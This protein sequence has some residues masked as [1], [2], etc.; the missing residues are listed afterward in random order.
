MD[1]KLSSSVSN[2]QEL[3]PIVPKKYIAH[4]IMLISCFV[5]WG[6][7]NNMT[8]NLVPAF[9]RIFMLEA[10]DA[11]LTQVAF[12]GSYAVLALPAAILIKKY[13]YRTGVLVGLGLYIVGAM[14]YIPA[15]ISQNFN[16]FLTSVFILA[17]GLSI[18]ETTCNPYVISLGSPET[19]VRRLNL[20]QAFNPLGSL[21][22][23]IMAK[24][25]ILSNLNPATY[26]ERVAMS[27]DALSAI[28]SNELLWVCVPY[29]GLVAIALVIWLFFKKSKDSEKDTS[30]ELNITHSIKKLVRIPRYAFG[31]VAQFF[32]VGVQIAV[33]TWT[34]SYVMTNLGLDEAAASG[35]YLIAI[36][37]FIV[38]RWIC[39]ALMKYIDPAIM[40]AVFAVGG[41]VFSLGTIY[42]PTNQSVWCLVAISACMSLMFPTI[43][44]IALK[45]LGEEVKVGAAGLIMAILGGA[46]IT[47]IMGK[48]IDTGVLSSIV[49]SFTG[50]QAAVR[51][52]FL[53]PAIC[54]LVVL[55]Y[56]LCFRTK[57]E[58]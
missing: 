52:S 33:W 7:L 20:A 56:S 22:G 2:K 24:Y 57:K 26:E 36:I 47:P 44:G 5:L 34:I 27:P 8:D 54:F 45:D 29:V 14:G 11:S 43:Y 41:I 13:S 25:I 38:C 6:L 46:V 12:Y 30:G 55:V 40:M 21:T 17:G 15:A 9:G 28:R 23:I 16:L 32:Y 42:L 31:V 48:M 1:G 10:A 4:F 49:P 58:A 50:T 51:S 3:T 39:T 18:L 19:S 53:I 37:S 35:Y